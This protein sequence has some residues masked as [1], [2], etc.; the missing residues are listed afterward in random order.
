[1]CFV[2]SLKFDFARL[3]AQIFKS[4]VCFKIIKYVAGWFSRNHMPQI[5]AKLFFMRINIPKVWNVLL[6]I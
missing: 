5:I 4:K 3:L 2:I 1:M 6:K